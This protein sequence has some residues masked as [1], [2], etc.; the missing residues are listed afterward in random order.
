MIAYIKGELMAAYPEQI[1]VDRGGIGY[2]ISVPLS[3]VNELPPV[4]ETVKIYTYLYVRED[5]MRLYGFLAKEDL[6]IFKLLITVS[7][8]GPKGG[9]GIL[10]AISPDELKFAILAG[11]TKGI[12]KAPGIGA[13][14]AGKLIL[15]LKDKISLEEAFEEQLE[16]KEKDSKDTSS[17]SSLRNDAIEA[18]T[19]L[20][21]SSTDAL[22]AVRKVELTEDMSVEELLKQSLKYML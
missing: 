9:L 1:I 17:Q 14:T 11:D 22:R 15:E 13:K 8:I 3:V 18:L 7:G 21:Y 12:A 6:E 2:E 19:A 4:G 16:K 20:G 10:S 5:A